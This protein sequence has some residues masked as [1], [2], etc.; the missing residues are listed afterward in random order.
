M[1]AID[2]A[3]RGV[4]SLLHCDKTELR[5]IIIPPYL[6]PPAGVLQ[7]NHSAGPKTSCASL[8]QSFNSRLK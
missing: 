8:H 4:Q 7:H 5:F 6:A 3:A 1:F 2:W